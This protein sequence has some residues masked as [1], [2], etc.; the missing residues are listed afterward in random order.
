MKKYEER[1]Q[2]I[3]STLSGED[4]GLTESQISSSTG[5]S[6]DILSGV[7]RLALRKGLIGRRKL[8]SSTSGREAYHYTVTG[9]TPF[10]KFQVGDMVVGNDLA[11]QLY[12]TTKKGFRGRV[13]EVYDANMIQIKELVGSGTPY[14]VKASAFDVVERPGATKETTSKT[15]KT[16]KTTSEAPKT[17]IEAPTL[18]IHEQI[19]R[20]R[21]FKPGD[22]VKVTHRVPSRDLGWKN[23]W[24]DEMDQ[25]IGREFRVHRL[26]MNSNKGVYLDNPGGFKFPAHVLT[27]VSHAPRK[28]PVRLSSSYTAEVYPGTKI[29]VGCTTIDKET[30]SQ[31]L[32]AWNS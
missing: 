27:L 30:F 21:D 8:L 7:L 22:L 19:L 26:N 28:V 23:S 31:I 20:E 32:E 6:P 18:S 17:T 5:I 11:E 16:P 9:K 2:K 24:I 13:T 25:C 14:H 4:K 1:I 3:L 15:P 12:R 29:V 10:Y